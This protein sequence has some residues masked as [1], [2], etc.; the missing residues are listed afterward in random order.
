M[1]G[2]NRFRLTISVAIRASLPLLLACTNKDAVLGVPAPAPG[3]T[4]SFSR[5]VQPIFSTGCAVAFCHG[6]PLGAP[7]SLLSGDAYGTLVGVASCEAPALKRVDA[8]HSD[9]S[10]LLVKLEGTQSTVQGAGGCAICNSAAGPV[11]DCGQRMPLGG[12]PFLS[13]VQIQLIRDW[14]DQGAS[15]N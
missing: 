2:R 4:I 8:G 1:P 12:P 9:A 7:M 11:G 13:D 5:D 10:Y 3:P 14:V 6:S 15:N